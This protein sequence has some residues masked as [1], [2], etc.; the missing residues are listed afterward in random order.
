M[1]V[2]GA[3]SSIPLPPLRRQPRKRTRPPLFGSDRTG[4]RRSAAPLLLGGGL[5]LPVGAGDEGGPVVGVA[6]PLEH[7][8]GTSRTGRANATSTGP[9]E[10]GAHSAIVRRLILA[11][12]VVLVDAAAVSL[13]G[14]VA[15]NAAEPDADGVMSQAE[16]GGD[17]AVAGTPAAQLEQLRVGDFRPTTQ[18]IHPQT[19]PAVHPPVVRAGGAAA[20]EQ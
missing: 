19:P 18:V 20:A 5:A 1:H 4:V 8:S 7:V 11:S 6:P 12:A 10:G 13:L 3:M 15:V 9:R 17:L 14:L 2:S 16:H